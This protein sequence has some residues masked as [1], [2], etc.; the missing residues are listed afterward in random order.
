MGIRIDRDSTTILQNPT[1]YN[2]LYYSAGSGEVNLY[3]TKSY[4]DSPSSSSA[5]DYKIYCY[6]SGGT[7]QI[8]NTA[9]NY[10]TILELSS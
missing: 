2:D 3:S 10:L 7:V 1:Y 8:P 5:I 6:T 4:I 9:I